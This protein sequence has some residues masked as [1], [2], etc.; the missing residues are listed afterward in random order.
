MSITPITLSGANSKDFIET[1][2]CGSILAAGGQCLA[3]ITFKPS[4]TG[5]RTGILSITDDPANSPQ[6]VILTGTATGPAP[7]ATTSS[8][9]LNFGNHAV[10]T[11]ACPDA[12]S[13]TNTGDATL[14]ITAVTFAGAYFSDFRQTNNCTGSINPSGACTV[15][16]SFKP[17]TVGTRSASLQI[18]DSASDSP[19]TVTISGE[20]SAS[21]APTVSSPSPAAVLSPTSLAFA[22]LPVTISSLAQKVTLTNAGTFALS[23]S[24]IAVSGANS[25]DSI[26]NNNCGTSVAAGGPCS[27]VV[28]FIPSL[29]GKRTANLF[30]SDNASGNPQT[31]SLTGGG[32]HDIVLSWAPSPGSDIL[33]INIYR[34]TVSGGESSSPLN[35][36]RV[37][38]T[39]YADANVS[40]RTKY[41]CV[42]T[43]VRSDGITQ[44]AASPETSATVP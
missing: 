22:N 42:L 9:F 3:N 40:S 25:G 31:V 4:A 24:S 44:S 21:G 8:L 37:S 30:V 19:Q 26:E 23:I 35:S 20:G 38:G 43:S 27:I 29:V 36:T 5:N 39:S 17:T 15:R 33:G 32:S 11:M 2:N 1:N 10:G 16:V 18:T 34:R 12:L 7:I 14:K 28:A 13:V 6:S 41:Y